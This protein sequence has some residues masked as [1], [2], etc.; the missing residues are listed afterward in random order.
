MELKRV[1]AITS[2]IFAILLIVPYGIETLHVSQ[3]RR[4]RRLLIVPYGIETENSNQ[5]S[6]PRTV[7]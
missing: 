2:S 3:P 1:D 7:F 6:K 5:R 4:I